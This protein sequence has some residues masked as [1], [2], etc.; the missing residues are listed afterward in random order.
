MSRPA[1]L[2]T[3][4]GIAVSGWPSQ[5]LKL[6]SLS[7]NSQDFMTARRCLTKPP[8]NAFINNAT[9]DR[10]THH[11]PSR[12]AGGH[13]PVHR[14]RRPGPRRTRLRTVIQW[15]KQLRQRHHPAAGQQLYLQRLGLPAPGGQYRPLDRP[16]LR[17]F[18]RSAHLPTDG[19][20]RG[21]AVCGT[22]PLWQLQRHA[23][24]DSGG[25]QPMVSPGGD[26][27]VQQTGE[28]LPQRQR[29]RFLGC[30]QLQRLQRDTRPGHSLGRQC[31]P[32]LQ[33][34]VG[35][36]ATLEHRPEPGGNSG[37]PE[38]AAQRG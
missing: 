31:R 4:D 17:Q 20:P 25:L 14:H 13:N 18:R 28:L 2:N 16:E 37:E 29:S 24:H 19:Q 6:L 38:P 1:N 36:G 12:P 21:S 3:A 5:V 23:Q 27:F 10:P 34:D 11:R 26:G 30:Q 8:L 15:R 22:G 32:P 7:I 33:R 35:R 9:D